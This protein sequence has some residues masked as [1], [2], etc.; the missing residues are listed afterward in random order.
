MASTAPA[1]TSGASAT[2]VA[3]VGATVASFVSKAAAATLEGGQHAASS[4]W[5]SFS[6]IAKKPAPGQKR[7]TASGTLLAR[8]LYIAT[9]VA[10]ASPTALPTIPVAHASAKSTHR[11]L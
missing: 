6:S 9:R 10:C 11:N 2:G 8:L 5:Y 4:A 3:T 7:M 1:S